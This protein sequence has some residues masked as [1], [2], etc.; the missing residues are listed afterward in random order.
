MHWHEFTAVKQQP[1]HVRKGGHGLKA[2][3]QPSSTG[4]TRVYQGILDSSYVIPS[5]DSGS[6]SGYTSMSAHEE[7]LASSPLPHPAISPASPARP[8]L[9]FLRGLALALMIWDSGLLR[10]RLGMRVVIPGVRQLHT[11]G[12]P[13]GDQPCLLQLPGLED[14]LLDAPWQIPSPGS[15]LI[16]LFHVRGRCAPRSPVMQ[17]EEQRGLTSGPGG[18][19]EGD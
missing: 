19:S 13:H 17:G 2:V 4:Q 3:V 7:L 12:T 18:G 16:L 9:F 10:N 11:H 5:T 6:R 15:E 14:S 8:P 1:S